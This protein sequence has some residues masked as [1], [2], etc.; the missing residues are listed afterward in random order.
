MP[1]AAAASLIASCSAALTNSWMVLD[2]SFS[3]GRLGRTIDRVLKLSEFACRLLPDCIADERGRGFPAHLSR[4]SPVELHGRGWAVP[5]VKNACRRC[6]RAFA[7]PAVF[8]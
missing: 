2:R 5:G 4:L 1:R 6:G 8:R 7:A 3:G